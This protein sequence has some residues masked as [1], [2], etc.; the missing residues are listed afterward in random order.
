MN[1]P[2]ISANLHNLKLGRGVD[3]GKITTLGAPVGAI[4]VSLLI[5][6][7]VVW[8]KLSEALRLRASNVEL[9]SRVGVLS[10]K[11]QLLSSLDKAQLDS[12]LG[13]SE[14]ILPSD[15][16]VFPFVREVELAAVRTG[17]LLNK[18]DATPGSLSGDSGEVTPKAGVVSDPAPKI[19]VKISMT[20]DYRSLLNFLSSMY[21]ISR[22]V[23]I[24]DFTISSSSVSG[25][26][27]LALRTSLVIDA[28]WKSLPSKLGSIESPIENLS[29]QELE[30]LAR[31]KA[32]EV[33]S[34][35]A[36]VPTVPTGRADLFAP[37]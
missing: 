28:Y 36:V 7:L 12:Q 4:F 6:I 37:F 11:V 21:S 30:I 15:K 5:L 34:P 35:P 18:V 19:Q 27:S 33:S 31:V 17:V 26:D 24:R 20:S 1:L 10:T 8:P 25:Q 2:E 22:V 3:L 9:S 32:A 14:Q 23:G 16:A 13:A 29:A